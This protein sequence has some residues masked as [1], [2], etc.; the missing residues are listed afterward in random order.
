LDGSQLPEPL[1]PHIHGQYYAAIIAGEAIG[2]SGQTSAVELAIHHPRISGYAFYEGQQLVR[3]IFINSDAYL[4][5]GTTVRT[6]VH[7]NLSLYGSAHCPAGQPLEP[8][9]M[10]I[11]R[12]AIGSEP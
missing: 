1:P 10:T 11:K 9:S 2:P 4:N 8:T 6:S 5:S 12:L 7:L 3:A